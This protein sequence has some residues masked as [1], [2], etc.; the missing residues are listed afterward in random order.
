MRYPPEIEEARWQK[1]LALVPHWREYLADGGMIDQILDAIFSTNGTCL[2]CRDGIAV[3]GK[4][5]C[6]HCLAKHVAYEMK[7]QK[8][9]GIQRYYG[10]PSKEAY[11]EYHKQ[12]KRN[13]RAAAAGQ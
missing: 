3:E 4:S 2:R 6:P 8:K 1:T 10:F 12:Y 13:K 11:N 5:L 7:S 9:R